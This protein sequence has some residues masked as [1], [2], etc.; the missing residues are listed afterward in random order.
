[1]SNFWDYI[2][3]NH[4][5]IIKVILTLSSEKVDQ[6]EEKDLVYKPK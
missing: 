4:E 3:F 6:I 5:N 2:K 1:M